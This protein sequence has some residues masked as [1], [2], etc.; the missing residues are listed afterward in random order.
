MNY[1]RI[2]RIHE[3]DFDSIVEE[4]GGERIKPNMSGS[5]GH[6]ADYILNEAIIELKLVRE[7]GLIKESRRKKVAEIFR[8]TQPD[9][10]VVVL[11]SKIL[12]QKELRKYYNLLEHPI[13]TAVRTAAKQVHDTNLRIGSDIT[14]VLIILNDGYTALS[15]EEFHEIVGKTVRNDTSKIDYAVA[16]GIYYYSDRFDNYFF[17]RFNLIPVN[18]DKPFPSYNIL[19]DSWNKWVEKYMT[20][21]VLGQKKFDDDRLPVIDL[22]FEIDGIEYVKTCPPMGKPSGFWPDGKRPRE[23]T[24]GMERCPPVAT[25][26]PK[27]SRTNWSKFKEIMSDESKLQDDYASWLRWA[28]EQEQQGGTDLQP[29]IAI[30]I[31]Y[32]DFISWYRKAGESLSIFTLC[33]FAVAVFQTKISSIIEGAINKM[34]SNLVIP[35]HI[36][37]LTEEIG[38]DRAF[39]ISS[40][41][42]INETSGFERNDIIVANQRLFFEY[43]L[44]LASA[45]AVQMGIETVAYEKNEKY[46]WT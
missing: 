7:E 38:Q 5:K 18:I 2:N 39:D 27:L 24:T 13:Q 45:Y 30:D 9:R 41:Y 21:V 1:I 32:E 44:A 3:K 25:C 40:I 8:K 29:F 33:C 26:F 35:S 42:Y 31:E 4:A 23:N 16:E 37:L 28:K 17:P 20:S 36:F 22:N 11:D 6:S 19:L 34:E 14:R 10:P 43:A 46:A 15:M 12:S